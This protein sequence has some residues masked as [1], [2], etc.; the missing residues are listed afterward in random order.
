[1]ENK[2]IHPVVLVRK[3]LRQIRRELETGSLRVNN[4]KPTGYY[5]FNDSSRKSYF[6]PLPRYFQV[7]IFF[8]SF[9]DDNFAMIILDDNFA[10]YFI[11]NL[12]AFNFETS[13]N[14]ETFKNR[15]LYFLQHHHGMISFILESFRRHSQLCTSLL[16][17]RSGLF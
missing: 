13:D 9:H 5:K 1:M 12:C 16:V 17:Q 6:S 7:L 10:T 15:S 4:N 11:Y 14:L 3:G 8:H 2:W